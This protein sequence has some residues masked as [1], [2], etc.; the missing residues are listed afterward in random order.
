MERSVTTRTYAYLYSYRDLTA[1][2]KDWSAAGVTHFDK[3]VICKLCRP[4]VF[5]DP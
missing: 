1:H 2:Q 5:N 4:G 3:P